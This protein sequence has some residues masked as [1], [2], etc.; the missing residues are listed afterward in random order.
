MRQLRSERVIK[1][2]VGH[3]RLDGAK[4]KQALFSILRFFLAVAPR[5]F[6]H[7]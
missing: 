6:R 7:P 2:I 4:K 1:G 5:L 3:S